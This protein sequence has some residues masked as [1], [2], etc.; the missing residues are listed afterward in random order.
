MAFL[1]VATM[2]QENETQ[3]EPN[4]LVSG[5]SYLR[6]SA[7]G[8]NAEHPP[9]VKMLCALPLL[10]LQP[11]LTPGFRQWETQEGKLGWRFLYHNRV[12]PEL[13]LNSARAVN[14]VLTLSFGLTVAFWTRRAFGELPA[15][16]ALAL[17]CWD[18]NL[19]AHGRYV[20]TDMAAA[21]AFFIACVS[22]MAFVEQPSRRRLILAGI[23]FGIAIVTK[24]SMLILPLVLLLMYVLRARRGA[25]MP[26]LARSM[27][28]LTAI[29]AVMILIVYRF[30]TGRIISD[31]TAS[32]FLAETAGELQ[33]DPLV[34]QPVAGLLDPTTRHGR[35]VHWIASHV[36]IPAY[37]FWKGIYRL[38]NHLYVG[39]DAYLLGEN[40][41]KGWWYY[42]PVAFA[43]KTPA[44]ELALMLLATVLAFRRR[45]NSALP[46]YGLLLPPAVYFLMSMMS[47]IDIGLRH[48]LPVYPFLFIILA[49]ILARSRF[50]RTAGLALL[51][52]LL[53]ES[54][55]A[56]PN[57]LAFFNFLAG[58]SKDGPRYLTDSNIDWG[59]DLRK[60]KT[61]LDRHSIP[62]VCLDY[63]GSGDAVVYYGINARD[64]STWPPPQS[65]RVAAA[66][67]TALHF[68]DSQLKP[69]LAC[70]PRARVGY[71][72]YI[73]DVTNGICGNVA[74]SAPDR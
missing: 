18:P 3:D 45:P 48:I 15:L 16:A 71:S 61:Y 42:F 74:A 41:N 17:F 19:I 22:W 70:E 56:Y 35:A 52:L 8:L 47:S 11:A 1:L 27:A 67:V 21:F 68:K 57:Y 40:S 26:P 59:Q 34:P 2:L 12:P 25:P 38:Y 6:E 5:Y 51:S 58:G 60:L 14:V 9:L 43:V 39:H 55:S 72:I 54:L 49:V 53:I 28:A 66:S 33:A 10:F 20:T 23:C 73:Y 31:Q 64:L 69:L 65:C 29:A 4:H 13:M 7:F 24:F 50:G 32:K 30:E 37:S 44:A 62:S 36:P 63:F 46:C